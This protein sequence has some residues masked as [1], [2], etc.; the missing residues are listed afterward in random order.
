MTDRKGEKIGWTVGWMG[1]FLWVAIIALIFL[2]QGKWAQG[3]SGLVL[4]G[5]A[6]FCILF[7]APWRFT[8]T[9]YWKLM[10]IPWVVLLLSVVWAVW[11]FGGFTSEDLR[12]WHFLWVLFIITPL[13]AI[14][15]RKWEQTGGGSDDPATTREQQP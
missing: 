7:F 6:V 8:S 9:R 12:W 1:G 15:G 4:T 14:G 3:V 2:Y 13:C 10:L 11:V 5:V